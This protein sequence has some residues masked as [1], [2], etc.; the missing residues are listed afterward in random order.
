MRIPD[1]RRGGGKDDAE[2][3]STGWSSLNGD[4][5]AADVDGPFGDRQSESG[6]AAIARATF[7][8]T[9]ETIEDAPTV[10]SGDSRSFVDD[11]DNRAFSIG[12]N[13]RND[14]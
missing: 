2:D 1:R 14:R 4:L 7:V 12:S 3:G 10:F 8:Q 5:A 13:A 11:V 6:A 9:E